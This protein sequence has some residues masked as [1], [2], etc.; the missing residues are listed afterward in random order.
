MNLEDN[1]GDIIGKSRTSANVSA[2]DAAAAA[3]LGI[4]EFSAL[5]ETGKFAR[6]PN[7]QAL[8]G[9]L[10]LHATKLEG[11]AN[12]WLPQK[13]D[14]SVW[15]ELRQITT[16]GIGFKVNCYL[17]WDEV[18]REAALFDTGFEAQPIF[19]L[20]EGNK[21]QLKHLFI[22]HTHADHVAA[23]DPIRSRFPKS[24]LHSSAKGA[25]VDQRNRGS[26]FIHLGSL[27]ISNRDTPG[28]AEDGVTYVIGNWPDD[29]PSVAVV[30]DAIFAG[31]MGGAKQLADLAKQKI[32]DQIF[33]LPPET[34]IC[35]GHGP[36]TTVGEEKA[37]NPFFA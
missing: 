23:L 1:V 13:R 20:L 31:S 25:P 5:E 37:N 10:G 17:I 12:G 6:R 7:L 14:L 18:T 35:P 26:D 4:D 16:A 21:L 3:G 33:S 29:A 34:L 8:A 2:E 22:T 19:D 15:R 36:V 27:R 32:R 24:K 9:K 30:G 11:I 28:H